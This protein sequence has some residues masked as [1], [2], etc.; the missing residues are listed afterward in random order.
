MA[1]YWRRKTLLISKHIVKAMFPIE[2]WNT[3]QWA[4]D[5]YA[6]CQNQTNRRH[7]HEATVMNVHPHIWKILINNHFSLQLRRILILQLPLFSNMYDKFAKTKIREPAILS[8]LAKELIINALKGSCE[9]L[10]LLLYL[11]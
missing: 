10:L 1:L 8:K 11:S 5:K 7:W 6:M 3:S 2:L 4:Y 9:L